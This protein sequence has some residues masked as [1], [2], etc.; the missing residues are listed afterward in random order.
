[1]H[2]TQFILFLRAI[3][4]DIQ[5]P[6]FFFFAFQP[7][8]M[9]IQTRQWYLGFQSVVFHELAYV[10]YILLSEFTILMYSNILL[11]SSRS[12]Y[13]YYYLPI[14]IYPHTFH[15]FAHRAIWQ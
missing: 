5:I 15:T 6:F 9:I 2:I 1:M 4:V 13:V 8:R 7:H 11:F 10:G 14:C 12:Q 3:H